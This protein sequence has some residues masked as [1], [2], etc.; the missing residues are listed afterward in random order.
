M[1]TTL[2]NRRACPPRRVANAT[3]RNMPRLRIARPLTPH[4]HLFRAG[5]GLEAYTDMLDLGSVL[6][7]LDE[8]LFA[9][10]EERGAGA[11]DAADADGGG[12][13]DAGDDGDDGRRGGGGGVGRV[14]PR[15]PPRTLEFMRRFHRL[16][17]KVVEVVTDFNLVSFVAVSANDAAS[18]LALQ[19]RIDHATGYVAT[20]SAA[21]DALGREGGVR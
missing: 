1:R 5:L 16:H 6:P 2:R 7:P 8:A 21:R 20:R 9:A 10:Q 18:L 12:G 4:L 13:D 19:A 3:Q 17:A 14:R 11:A 15:F